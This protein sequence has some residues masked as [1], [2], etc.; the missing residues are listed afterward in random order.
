M[1]LNLLIVN[2]TSLK[3]GG[4]KMK[5]AINTGGGMLRA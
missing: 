3:N 1:R 2:C 5:I 4:Y